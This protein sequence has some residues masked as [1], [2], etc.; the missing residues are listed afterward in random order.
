MGDIALTN[1]YPEENPYLVRLPASMCMSITDD[2]AGMSKIA[3]E[4]YGD[5]PETNED[6]WPCSTLCRCIHNRRMQF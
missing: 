5:P 4:M 1:T 6:R 3:R 2:E